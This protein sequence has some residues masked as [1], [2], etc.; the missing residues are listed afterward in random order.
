VSFLA[1]I[2][3][4]IAQVTPPPPPPV[5]FTP[6]P[7]PSASPTAPATPLASP[8]ASPSALAINPAA[9]NLHPAQSQAIAVSGA[10][11]PITAQLDTPLA[12]VTVDQTARTVTVTA[13]EQTGRATLIIADSTGAT[14]T[15][16][17]RVA[18]DA[19]IVPPAISLR[20]TGTAMDPVW[21][22]KQIAD[23]VSRAIQLQPGAGQPQ[24]A[25]VS[26]PTLF[27]PGT[28]AALPVQITVA[29]GSQY[30][31]VATNATLNLQNVNAAPFLPP[32][33]FYD[34][35]PEKITGDGVL[36]RNEVSAA[37]PA[38]LYYYHENTNDAR[39]L[40]V[41]LSTPASTPATVQLIDASAGPNI[42]VMSVGHAVSRDFLLAKPRNQGI[43]VD[44]APQTPYVVDAFDMKP[45][46]GAAGSIGVHLLDGGPVTVTVVAVPADTPA[47]QLAA[48][49]SQP[50]LPDDGHHRTGVF[51]ITSYGDERL[52]Y[53]AGSDD[54]TTQYGTTT[55]PLAG[56][57]PSPGHDYGDYGVIRTFTFD[58]SN[59]TDSPS[60]AYLYERPLGGG[61]RSSFL[62]DGQLVQLG[63]ARLPQRYQIGTP[64]ELQPR[65]S[66]RVTV[67]TMTDGGSSYPLEIGMTG[68]PP[69]PSTPPLNAPD[70]CFPK[71]QAQPSA[72]PA[73]PLPEPTGRL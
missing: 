6:A 40:L 68:T 5:L 42:D 11:G 41:V 12:T 31:D 55:P 66:Y 18:F 29:G 54:A 27:A 60:T 56:P 72:S 28:S 13:A 8:S 62:V 37:A 15:V 23:A 58:V 50:P 44:V 45:R 14:V 35:D 26:L 22:Q 73:V 4:L 52:A 20:V 71:P 30:Y 1:V 2:L 10:N 46:D 59:P 48:Y 21:L 49:L 64:F 17:V 51:N 16:P 36:Y 24:I 57:A 53:T 69:L 70:G 67:Q 25:G 32:L 39:R 33:L 19:A 3:A 63:C 61:V 43:V 47:A 34:D 7:S 38:R 9:L 65:S